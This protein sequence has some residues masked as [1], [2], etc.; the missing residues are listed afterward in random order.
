MKR[1][2]FIVAMLVSGFISNAQIDIQWGERFYDILD[3]CKDAQIVAEDNGG[4]Y[5]WFSQEEYLGEGESKIQYYFARTNKKGDVEKVVK[6]DFPHSSFKIEQTWRAGE[7]VG[8]ILSRITQDKEPQKKGSKKKKEDPEIKGTAHIYTQYFH[9]GDMRLMDKPQKI[10]VFRYFTKKGEK[11]YLFNFSENKTKMAFCFFNR[12]SSGTKTANLRVYDERMNVLWEKDHK[13]N[14]QNDDYDIKDVAVNNAGTELLLGIRSFSTA[15]KV[16]HTDGKVHLIWLNQYEERMHTEQLEKA[17][18][19]DLKCA[20]NMEGDYLVAGYYGTAND[21]P[22][23]SHGS[24]SFL[25]D[26]RRGYLKK[27]SRAEFK[28][29]END[30]MVKKGLPLP[31][32]M[33]SCIRA[34][35]PMV[36]G[37]LVMVGEQEFESHIIP[38]K[39]RGEDPTGEEAMYYR[40]IILTNI[41]KYGMVTGNAYI[42]K[43]QKD[44]EG[45]EAYNSFGMTRD[46][47]GIY[48]MFNDHIKNYDDN[49]FYAQRCY[50]ADKLRTQ[51]NFV[52]IFS[53]GSYRWSKAYD[54]KKNKMPFFRTVYLTTLK[55]IMFL[56]RY[57][58]HNILGTFEIR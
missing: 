9:L 27:D 39:R 58:D 31:S 47:Y 1:L 54:T 30:G 49:A 5:L 43:R 2:F 40:D 15:K 55:R 18:A 12:D 4:F 10:N 57:Q 28:E 14:I 50:N 24:F 42:P 20:F 32:N 17:W 37:N 13:L 44:E 29:Y 16:K 52:Q 51:V 23:L 46:R 53:D 19:T 33:T 11:P 6:I 21:K 34:L 35:V 38:P 45:L 36:G 8:F 25:Y 26:Q 7:C 22:T 3:D 56:G 41:D 48:I